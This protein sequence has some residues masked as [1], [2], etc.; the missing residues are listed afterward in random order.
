MRRSA[1]VVAS[2]LAGVVTLAVPTL[3]AA[4]AGASYVALGDSYSSG[5]GTRTY[6]NDGSSCQRSVYAYPSLIAAGNGLALNLRA[7]SGAT[8]AD[9]TRLQLSP[10]TPGTSYVTLT[11][12]GNDAGFASVLTECAKPSWASNCNGAVDKAQSLIR[13]QL[14]GR[15]DRLYA[16]IKA[17][18]PRAEVV[19]A[20]YP[21]VFTREDCNLLTWFSPTEEDRLNATADLLNATIA[22]AASRARIG[23][24]SPTSRFA[25][26]AVCDDVEWINGLSSPTSE[27]YHPNRSGHS[28]GY[29]PLVQAALTGS[30]ARTTLSAARA[31]VLS[32]RL[33]VQQRRYADRDRAIR[34]E[35]VRIPDLRSPTIER[36]AAKVG[37][38]L[39]SRTSIDAADR[40]YA[41][42]QARELAARS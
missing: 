37:V 26:H 15:F 7:C 1:A 2:T 32:A 8:T 9:V 11:V 10:L 27:S 17:R 13:S 28:S 42:K 39:D 12:G 3:P 16:S 6:L 31:E 5:T 29:A 4:A 18:A 21:R 14:P 23:Y 34:P 20:G 22:A 36:A 35:V 41:R 30:T 24:S 38:D 19:V 25:G 33:A 40:R